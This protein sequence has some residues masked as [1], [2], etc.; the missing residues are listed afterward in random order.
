M[1]FFLPGSQPRL[2]SVFPTK[3]W[4]P[5]QCRTASLV[6]TPTTAWVPLCLIGHVTSH[7]WRPELYPT[8]PRML[9]GHFPGHWRC[10]HEN[11]H[12]LRQPCRH[13]YPCGHGQD[14]RVIPV[15]LHRSPVPP[16]VLHSSPLIPSGSL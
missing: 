9:L 6:A 11:T 7:K 15:L 13:S 12:P 5:T 16:L 3:L 1:A 14:R 4:Y 10:V 2:W 8:F